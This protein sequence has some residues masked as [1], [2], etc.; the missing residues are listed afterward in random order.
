MSAST[1]G[2]S[3][4]ELADSDL[5]VLLAQAGPALQETL[6]RYRSG[7][8]EARMSVSPCTWYSFIDPDE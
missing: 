8:S 7:R 5:D 3:L 4:T 1:T 2:F 6:R